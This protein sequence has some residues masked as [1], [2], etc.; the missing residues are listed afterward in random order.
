[1]RAAMQ[2]CQARAV[3]E[4]IGGHPHHEP[5]DGNQRPYEHQGRDRAEPPEYGLM[6][7]GPIE[8]SRQRG[9]P[10][11][12]AWVPRVARPP[13]FTPT[14]L[15]DKASSGTQPSATVTGGRSMA[16]RQ[17]APKPTRPS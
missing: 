17:V 9:R 14:A 13:V 4:V 15:L 12:I 5:R 2:F 16:L 6:T 7:A 8:Q 10:P 11:L 3:Q 1:M